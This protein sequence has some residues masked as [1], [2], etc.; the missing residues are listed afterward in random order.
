MFHLFLSTPTF[1]EP[2]FLRISY[3]WKE[4]KRYLEIFDLAQIHPNK[5]K[6]LVVEIGKKRNSNVKKDLSIYVCILSLYIYKEF[7]KS[8]LIYS[9][10][11]HNI[12]LQAKISSSEMGALIC[13][14]HSVAQC[15]VVWGTVRGVG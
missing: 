9:R 15:V 10:N 7:L 1:P 5:V 12:I 14:C 4:Y 2:I 11:E 6:G 8:A 13:C 3:L